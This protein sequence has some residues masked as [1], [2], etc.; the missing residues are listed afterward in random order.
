MSNKGLRDALIVC[1]PSRTSL[2]RG[3]AGF[4]DVRFILP[5]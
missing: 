3:E 5:R 1:F 4:I 2:Q